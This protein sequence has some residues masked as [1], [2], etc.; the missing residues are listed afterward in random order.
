MENTAV[1]IR[2]NVIAPARSNMM[3]NVTNVSTNQTKE[4]RLRGTNSKV[5]STANLATII[6]FITPTNT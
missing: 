5:S 1:I 6:Q 3:F 2:S 4:D